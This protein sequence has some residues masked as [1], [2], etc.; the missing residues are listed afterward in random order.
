M[1]VF[2]TILIA[3]ASSTIPSAAIAGLFMF[4]VNRAQAVKVLAEAEDISKKTAL[5]EAEAA[6]KF[7]TE[8]F[9]NLAKDY[10]KVEQKCSSCMEKLKKMERRDERR[11]R[12]EDALIEAWLEAIPLLPADAEQT[13]K[14]RAAAEAA[15]VAKRELD[16]D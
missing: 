9:S 15:R 10:E 4:K 14:L 6:L 5:S 11:D 12:I 3:I 1:N 7:N 8:R 2:A 16:N 13:A